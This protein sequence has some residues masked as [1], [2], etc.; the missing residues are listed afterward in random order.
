M[1]GC[2]PRQTGDFVEFAK[3]LQLVA[4]HL[5]SEGND[6]AV[7]GGLALAVH[8]AGRMTHDVDIATEHSA[9]DALV[10]HLESLGYE[11][12]HCSEGYSNHAH[13]DATMGR[14][15]IVYLDDP[16]AGELFAGDGGYR[17]L[18]A[19]SKSRCRV[20]TKLLRTARLDRCLGAS[21]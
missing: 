19:S 14:V 8:G 2:P 18:A 16:T 13:Q 5:K 6:W 3:V 1:R 10:Q 20:R 15:D 21:T 7:V 11:T 4:T 9:Q 12:L 17:C